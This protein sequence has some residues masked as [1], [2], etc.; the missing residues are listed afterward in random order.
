MNSHP[1]N[2]P[3]T[4]VCGVLRHRWDVYITAPAPHR[5]DVVERVSETGVREHEAVGS[6]G[7]GRV[8]VFIKGVA[9]SRAAMLQ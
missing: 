6:F 7:R 2:V 3:R 9:P 1:V 8:S 4:N 5:K